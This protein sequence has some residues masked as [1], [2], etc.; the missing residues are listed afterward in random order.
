MQYTLDRILIGNYFSTEEVGAYAFW[1]AIG[2]GGGRAL[3]QFIFMAFNPRI[4]Q[5]YDNNKKGMRQL[6][7][8]IL[9]Y[10]CIFPVILTLCAFLVPPSLAVLSLGAGYLKYQEVFSFSMGVVFFLGL[11]QLLVKPLE[12]EK[13]TFLIIIAALFSLVVLIFA[14]PVSIEYFGLVG[15]AIAVIFAAATYCGTGWVLTIIQLSKMGDI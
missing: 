5:L 3:F 4:F 6:R 15:A 1:M 13:K 10:I 9:L 2:L 14:L 8:I 7:K 12:F 11:T